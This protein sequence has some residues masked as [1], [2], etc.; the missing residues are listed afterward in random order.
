MSVARLLQI[1][2]GPV[3]RVPTTLNERRTTMAANVLKNTERF[4]PTNPREGTDKLLV[5]R[6]LT[7]SESQYAAIS[8]ISSRPSR[9]ET[10]PGSSF[11]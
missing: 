11:K 7:L 8:P 9:Y 10:K 4:N 2:I 3:G 5:T 6:R 1:Q